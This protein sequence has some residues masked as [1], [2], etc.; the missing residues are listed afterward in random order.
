MPVL[1]PGNFTLWLLQASPLISDPVSLSFCL[2]LSL[3]DPN[4]LLSVA[5]R[6][7]LLPCVPLNVS[8]REDSLSLSPLHLFPCQSSSISVSQS[9]SLSLCMSLSFLLL[10]SLSLSFYLSVFLSLMLS[11][12][13]LFV[14]V[15]HWLCVSLSLSRSPGL[16][17]L[18]ACLSLLAFSPHHPISGRLFSISVLILPGAAPPAR[19][20]HL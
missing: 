17:F 2:P 18:G 20:K 19:L 6:G 5:S 8:Q 16:L 1:F 7:P 9:L 14:S 12:S 10:L 4:Y 11:V 3:A 13:L 15:S